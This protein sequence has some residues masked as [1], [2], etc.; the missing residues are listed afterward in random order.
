MLLACLPVSLQA[1]LA[2]MTNEE[3]A[4][5][6]GQQG[7]S[8]SLTDPTVTTANK[9]VWQND[10]G[11]A[12]QR[13]LALQNL[14]ITYNPGAS[15]DL[16]LDIG[17]Q[18]ITDP[19]VRVD[20]SWN[21]LNTTV[22]AL[23]LEAADGS[24]LPPTMASMDVGTSGGVTF[25][26]D[27]GIL[28]GPLTAFDM[29]LFDPNAPGDIILRQGGPGSPEVSLADLT[30]QMQ[31]IGCA[32][33]LCE[34]GISGA[35]RLFIRADAMLVD[36]G[37][38]LM[39]KNSPVSFDRTGRQGMIRLGWSGL[40]ESFDLS[41]GSAALAGTEGLS[42]TLSTQFGSSFAMSLGRPGS[43]TAAVF[44][45]YQN[46]VLA[47]ADP[48]LLLPLTLD[49]VPGAT[50]LGAICFGNTPACSGGELLPFVT[51]TD[52]LAV[53]MRDGSLSSY[54]TQV[55]VLDPSVAGD[56]LLVDAPG[57]TETL[58]W[59]LGTVLGRIDA[60]L[61][62]YAGF[63]DDSNGSLNATGMTA[64]MTLVSNSPGHWARLQAGDPTAGANWRTNTHFFIA[65]T[66][67]SLDANNS[68]GDFNT[69]TG[70]GDQMG[71]GIFNA[72]LL[73]DADD[74]AIRMA[75]DSSTAFSGLSAASDIPAGGIGFSGGLWLQSHSGARFH[76]RGTLGG[77]DL[78]NLD[79]L[80]SISIA[81]IRIDADRFVLAL[82]PGATTPASLG[83]E[84]LLDL[85]NNTYLS[86]AEPTR[87]DVDLRVEGISGR[88][89][90]RDGILQ[91]R[92]SAENANNRP[93]L[94][95]GNRVYFGSNAESGMP[96]RG[97]VAFGPDRLMELAVPSGQFYS[98][99]T[100]RPQL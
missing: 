86:L 4:G 70:A 94:V 21:D 19:R 85:N 61:A 87:P 5:V 100:L 37:F 71:F 58:D 11:T 65:D 72:D 99:I 47:A 8:L 83:F 57:D 55:Q 29:R 78:L 67:T 45:S 15:V 28:L 35:G 97:H 89:L 95:L 7:V 50:N 74:M 81:D 73:V 10:V 9:L 48:D 76:V 30:M 40:L 92:T 23:R 32:T 17:S 13:G 1:A 98:E 36:T 54:N 91:L 56:P 44:T 59:S 66:N 84:G 69:S 80:A 2:P 64:D 90:I 60:N 52:A 38:E 20:L 62:L 25:E 42:A 22:G 77:G 82:S 41:L 96:L 18:V 34:V 26:S 68:D 16:E 33:Q 24:L 53:T 88:A 27:D 14:A 39:F 43:E 12:A 46:M 49:V 31:M 79:N 51:D 6:S 3:M 75:G 93:S 63:D